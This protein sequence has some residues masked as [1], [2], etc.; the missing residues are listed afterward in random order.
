VHHIKALIARRQ[1]E[2]AL[3]KAALPR[4]EKIT[5]PTDLLGAL[6]AA[7]IDVEDAAK[8]KTGEIQKGL[9]PEELLG[10]VCESCASSGR[11]HNVGDSHC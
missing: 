11:E 9:T 6:V 2:I 7:Q 5:P 1:G 8:L 4:G 3:E 10:N